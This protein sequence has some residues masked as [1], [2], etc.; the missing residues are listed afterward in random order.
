MRVGN[1]SGRLTLFSDQRAVDVEKASSGRFGSD[2]QAVYDR[3]DEFTDWV[4]R[5]PSIGGGVPFA[6]EDLG[7][8][9]PRPSQVFAIGANY[10]AHAEEGGV[11]VP[12]SP[13]VFTK[14][15]SSFTGPVGD[16]VL[17]GETVD[18]EAELVA[19]IG[20]RARNVTAERGWEYI[21]GLTAGQDVSE[22]TQQLKGGA[23]PQMGLGKSF[24]GFSPSGPW[25]V[26]LDE[27][28][29][30]GDLELGCTVNGQEVQKARTSDL[31]FPLPALVAELSRVVTLEPGDVIFTGTP[32]GVGLARKPPVFLAPGDELVTTVQGIGELRHR[33]VSA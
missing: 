4:A 20:K 19:V 5:S 25:L 31:V 3:W 24:P 8:P 2:P 15:P 16:I 30:P 12:E 32:G 29:D 27:F 11:E 7:A 6:T 21:A 10:R 26:S 23:Y 13:M 17:A 22:R 18:W 9:A 28:A 33:F 14:W 1:L